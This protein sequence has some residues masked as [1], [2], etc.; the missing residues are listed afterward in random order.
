M[1][2]KYYDDNLILNILAYADD[3]VLFSDNP[4]Q[5][6]EMLNI[7]SEWCKKWRLKINTDKTKI[8]QFR[9]SRKQRNNSCEFLLQGTVLSE[10]QNYKYLGVIFD[11]HLKYDVACNM[12]ASAARRALGKIIYKSKAISGIG[13]NTFTTLYNSM[14]SP[15]LEYGSEIRASC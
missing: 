10:V 3:I 1:G 12:L 6:Q 5:L 14:V 13:F 4:E 7:V 2:V 15:I 8:I 11:E 9:K